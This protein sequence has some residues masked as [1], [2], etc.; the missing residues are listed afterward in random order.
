MSLNHPNRFPDNILYRFPS[1]TLHN[2]KDGVFVLEL[3]DHQF[4]YKY[5]NPA[6]VDLL[7]LTEN[8]E[9]KTIDDLFPPFEA[10]FL[11][12]YY[13]M[14]AS[15]NQITTFN[16]YKRSHQRI[17]TYET[18]LTPIKHSDGFYILTIIRSHSTNFEQFTNP[19]ILKNPTNLNEQKTSAEYQLDCD[20]Y[21]LKANREVEDI[22]GYLPF[23]LVGTN[24]SQLLPFNELFKVK[25]YFQQVLEGQSV[26]FKTELVHKNG[27]LV[28]FKLSLK[29]DI[30]NG[31]IKGVTGKV[32]K[33]LKR[34]VVT[35]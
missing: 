24:F 25:Q 20:G 14:T 19:L 5:A 32:E 21:F 6:G 35:S 33:M 13:Y 29:P 22:I 3:L 30:K 11:K 18:E 27:Q 23:E 9:G 4:I 31:K 15:T 17:G 2:S 12:K 7:N 26:Q 28:T 10:A 16:S 34:E 8:V 1:S